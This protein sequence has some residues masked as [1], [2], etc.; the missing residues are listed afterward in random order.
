MIGLRHLMFYADQLALGIDSG[1]PITRVLRSLEQTAPT[2]RLKTIS[3]DVR[4]QIERGETLANAFRRFRTSFPA[5]FVSL[6]EV[7]ERTGHLEGV[8][9]ELAE[10][11]RQRYL[12]VQQL[13]WSLFPLAV[14]AL[15][16]VS[17]I[18][19]I[20]YL[21]GG[22]DSSVLYRS[23]LQ[24][25]LAVV[26]FLGIPW[27][28]YKLFPA[29]RDGFRSLF[30]ILWPV[31]ALMRK[32]SIYRFS[33]SMALGLHAGMEIRATI[34]FSAESM[35][36]PRMQRRALRAVEYIDQGQSIAQALTNTG[37]FPRL[38][39][40]LY[41]TGEQSGRLFEMMQRVATVTKEQAQ[42]AVKAFSKSVW[43]ILYTG[44]IVY[45]GYMVITFWRRI[46]GQMIDT[47][48]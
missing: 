44:L 38:I 20:G 47:F 10:Y 13:K 4:E 34:R 21:I 31:S 32:F 26:M 19:L 7:G 46:Y 14:Y 3:H 23:F 15:A 6:I 18:I 2:R 35:G 16:C 25:G 12:V 27:A 24:L 30:S 36:D 28:L 48:F 17:G 42:E 37:I 45:V 11:Y 33:E 5:M 1:L 9:K 43:I 22:Q 39:V 8:A 40:D 29:F 41:E